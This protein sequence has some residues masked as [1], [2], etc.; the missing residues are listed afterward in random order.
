LNVSSDDFNFVTYGFLTAMRLTENA[1][2][3][4]ANAALN[5]PNDASDLSA[6]KNYDYTFATNVTRALTVFVAKQ[7]GFEGPQTPPSLSLDSDGDGYSDEIEIAL[8][9]NPFDPTSTPLNLPPATSGGA[10]DTAAMAITINFI[11]TAADSI[12]V[13]GTIPIPAGFVPAGQYMIVDCAGIVKAVKL[14]AGGTGVKGNNTFQLKFKRQGST[15][16]A[17]LATFGVTLGNGNFKRALLPYG[18]IDGNFP[19]K[20]VTIPL[21]IILNAKVY[22]TARGMLYA[23]T[24]NQGGIAH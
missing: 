21:T 11:L 2:N 5:T 20:P 22:T 15:V 19:G 8:G 16:P 24:K 14:R 18:F 13:R 4:T 7:A 12:A 10:L 23:A 9:S 6:G 1:E 3:Q 17:Q